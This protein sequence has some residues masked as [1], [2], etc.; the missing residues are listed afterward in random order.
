MLTN[1][2]KMLTNLINFTALNDLLARRVINQAK[3][4]TVQGLKFSQNKLECL[5]ERMNL[6]ETGFLFKN[7]ECSRED[8]VKKGF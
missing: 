6:G 4:D 1:V 3:T 8:I 2:D 5:S 7:L